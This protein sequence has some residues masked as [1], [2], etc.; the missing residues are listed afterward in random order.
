MA[1]VALLPSRMDQSDYTIAEQELQDHVLDIYG[2]RDSDDDMFR[3]TLADEQKIGFFSLDRAAQ[4][5]VTEVVDL[6][7]MTEVLQILLQEVAKLGRDINF[8]KHA[9][10]AD[11]E[12][13]LQ[14]KSLELYCRIN[15]RV[16]ELEKIHRDRVSSLRKAFRQQL[17]DAVSR[18]SVMYKKN[19]ESNMIRERTRQQSDLKGQDVRMQEMK[20]TIARNESIIQML[21]LQLQQQQAQTAHHERSFFMD[22]ASSTKSKSTRGTESPVMAM[23]ESPRANSRIQAL[24]DEM[25]EMRGQQE[26]LQKKGE[27]LEEALDIKD[28]EVAGLNKTIKNLQRQ[29]EKEKILNEQL[30]HEKDEIK[31]DAEKELFSSKK[32]ALATAKAEAARLANQDMGKIKELMDQKKEL[33]KELAVERSKASEK[34]A[35]GEV[36]AESLKM[37]DSK[38]K[39][40]IKRLKEEID[41]VHRTWEKK[42]TILQA[43]M[44]AL[45]DES[46]LRQTLQRQAATLHHASVSYAADTPLGISPSKQNSQAT[47]QK[48]PLP[49]IRRNS[50][51]VSR[52]PN[53]KDYISYTVSAQSGRGTA[54]MSV[55]ENQV[56]S[57]T[58]EDLPN[59]FLPLPEPPARQDQNDA[60][61]ESRPSTLSHV[62]VL[63]LASV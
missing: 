59:D 19:L 5:E 25:E 21:Q 15:E 56:M 62:V 2:T 23:S 26:K 46:Y 41:K 10:Q 31:M 60:V 50:R 1:A 38:L 47:P 7:E 49:D 39:A 55:E 8:T 27:R 53:D 33:E 13:K 29:V 24:E 3:P 58:E 12:S 30:Q 34:S 43:S 63:P 42:F 37:S 52:N 28:E 14:S 35:K 4:T 11:Y 51:S 57:D 54:A 44:H 61:E 18:L 32:L 40:E 17:A 6:K 36:E 22:D 9:M 45:K 48:K 16:S 20:A